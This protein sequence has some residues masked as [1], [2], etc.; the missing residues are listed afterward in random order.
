MKRRKL[1]FL[2]GQ[3]PRHFP[4]ALHSEASAVHVSP[5]LIKAAASEVEEVYRQVQTA[6]CGL[7]ETEAVRRRQEYGPNAVVMEARYRRSVLLL[8]AFLNPLV[9]LLL[10]LAVVSF[11]TGDDRAA[12]VMIVMVLLGVA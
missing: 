10:I 11:L 6:P 9:V 2:N 1:K 3:L 4:H 8:K 12:A 5:L 7:T